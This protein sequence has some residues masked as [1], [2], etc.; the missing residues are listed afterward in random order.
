MEE[1]INLLKDIVVAQL[2]ECKKNKIAPSKEV[3]DTIETYKHLYE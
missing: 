1:V 2:E 3:L